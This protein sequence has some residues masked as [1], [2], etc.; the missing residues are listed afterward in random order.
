MEHIAGTERAQDTAVAWISDCGILHLL[1]VK[2]LSEDFRCC[3]ET[4]F[5]YIV[6]HTELNAGYDQQ[7]QSATQTLSFS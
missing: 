7:L 3:F 5:I 1:G 2:G 6:A 4:F